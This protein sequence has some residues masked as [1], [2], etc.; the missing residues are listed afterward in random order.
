MEGKGMQAPSAMPAPRRGSRSSAVAVAASERSWRHRARDPRVWVVVIGCALVALVSAAGIARPLDRDE[1]AFLL[2]AGDILHG[3][4]P[5]RDVFDQK[6][7]GVYYLLAALLALTGHLD[8]IQQVLVARAAFAAINLLT[9][10]GLILLGQRWWRLE[11]GAL[12]ALLWLLAS[13]IYGGDQLF[14]EPVA[15]ACTVWAV[16]VAAGGS[17]LR[18][19][20]GA[21]LLLALGSLFKQTA[22]LALP[23]LALVLATRFAPGAVW[24]RPARARIL[25]LLTLLAGVAMPWLAVSGLFALA[26]ALGSMI[27]QVII[28]NVVR[29]PSDS[30]AEIV[31]AL[32]D[33]I[34]AFRALWYVAGLVV[35]VGAWRWIRGGDGGQRRTPSLG[36]VMCVVIGALALLP[37]KSHAYPHYWLQVAPWAAL[38]AA[39]GFAAVVDV[40]RALPQPALRPASASA[41]PHTLLAWILVVG[42]IVPTCGRSII[43]SA[44]PPDLRQQAGLG[45]WI[46]RY[47]PPGTRLL[48]A[49]A[50]PEYYYLADNTPSDSF[51]YLLPI[52]LTPALLVQVSADLRAGRYDVVV[53]DRNSGVGGDDTYFTGLAELRRTLAGRYHVAAIQESLQL[54]VVNAGVPA[55]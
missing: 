14:T 17:G 6:A 38:V 19:A 13:P 34:Q 51:V 49:P 32:R 28:S 36:A 29:Y 11:I 48:V 18:R 47:A 2:L 22:V 26:G 9:A 35:A 42:I 40:L 4:I 43:A 12:A 52:N 53:W 44:R 30:R 37:F 3:R 20:F 55:G 41:G 1:G 8:K 45:A 31:G 33:G 39:M 27:D 10:A 54:Y 21:G 46:A 16:V 5:Y 50:E 15:V 24:W 23:G 25:A 7:P